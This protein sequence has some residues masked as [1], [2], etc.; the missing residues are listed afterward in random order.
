MIAYHPSVDEPGGAP[1]VVHEWLRWKR[2]SLG[3]PFR[4]LEYRCGVGQA[5]SG[6]APEDEDERV[7]VA[8]NGPDLLAVTTR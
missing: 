2:S 5:A 1:V 3:A 4:F 8:L 6:E 7:E